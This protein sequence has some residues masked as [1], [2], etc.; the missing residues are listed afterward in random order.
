MRKICLSLFKENKLLSFALFAIYTI[1]IALLVILIFFV[2]SFD[3]TI[4]SYF[5]EYRVFDINLITVPIFREKIDD[6]KAIDGVE[7]VSARMVNDTVLF[8]EEGNV[9]SVNVYSISSDESWKL[10]DVNTD[11]YAKVSDDS[12]MVSA[13]FALNNHLVPGDIV[14]LRVQNEIRE[15]TI[16]NIVSCPE[17][18]AVGTSVGSWYDLTSFGIVYV[19]DSLY[20]DMIGYGGYVNNVRLTLDNGTDSNEIS[21]ESKVS[22][23]NV[24]SEAESIL[25]S[26]NI[27]S[28]QTYDNSMISKQ[29]DA[30]IDGIRSLTIIV[31]A[32]IAGVGLLF[33]VI[34]VAQIVTRSKRN[35]GLL[36]ALGYDSWRICVVFIIYV[37]T[38]ATIAAV[39]GIGVGIILL[40]VMLNIY[41]N[42]YF[43]P[44]IILSG[45]I[46]KV[47]FLLFGVYLLAGIS[48]IVSARAISRVEPSIACNGGKTS[49]EDDAGE[50]PSWLSG[51]SLNSFSKLTITMIY[52]NL[53]R[54]IATVF[55]ILSCIV[56]CM[57][58]ISLIV[59]KNT[60][61][62]YTFNTRYTIDFAYFSTNDEYLAQVAELPTVS[63]THITFYYD[64]DYEGEALRIEVDDSQSGQT[65]IVLEE[66]FARRHN[67][68]I[69]DTV[70]VLGGELEVTGICRQYLCSTQYVS[71][72]QALTLGL[73]RNVVIG[74]FSSSEASKTLS[75]I[76][77]EDMDFM[78]L[79]VFD[80]TEKDVREALNQID[81]PC[82][83]F[84]IASFALGF[85]IMYNMNI[86]S[87]SR[88]KR[89]FSTLRAL[90]TENFRFIQ[91]LFGE[92]LAEFIPACLLAPVGFPIIGWIFVK[93]SSVSEEFVPVN[94]GLV[95]VISCIIAL[96]CT[97]VGSL[98]T[99]FSVKKMD[100]VDEL[101]SRE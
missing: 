82:Y 11:E 96:V 81:M 50:I 13:S 16:T 74:R 87:F 37:F 59:S 14:R 94:Q 48:V 92:A 9:K 1:I 28:S 38:L 3:A 7:A 73:K 43:F 2:N 58:S 77:A 46:V 39:I 51:I 34:F 24:L 29:I 57:F 91:I 42:F 23:D 31:P 17:T 63:D 101:N 12:V 70:T 49:F 67:L 72:A 90:G 25:G 61:T 100:Y 71:S 98:V 40:K 93:I 68:K 21:D 18:M 26:S 32:F 78:E 27:V 64:T 66:G 53:G 30:S 89:E 20:E 8:T 15:V 52:R 79:L 19:A 99:F 75:S 36:R 6:L 80:E 5:D 69:G 54:V 88:R 35:I 33:S 86:I 60:A 41:K 84:V 55:C 62:D 97:L 95:F 45:S 47:L 56:L 22:L 4:K 10:L 44:Y 85:L 76:A 83:V 65:G